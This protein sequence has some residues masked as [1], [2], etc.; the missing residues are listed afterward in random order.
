MAQPIHLLPESDPFALLRARASGIDISTPELLAFIAQNPGVFR[1]GDI[2]TDGVGPN[3]GGTGRVGDE[4]GI[5]GAV[6]GA[7]GPTPVST[8]SFNLPDIS[9]PSGV[10]GKGGL[11]NFENAGRVAG[12]FVPMPGSTP[13]RRSRSARSAPRSTT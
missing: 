9:M 8:S 2:G 6:A 11:I 1:R 4:A 13:S 5:G 10:F 3:L 12:G 7:T